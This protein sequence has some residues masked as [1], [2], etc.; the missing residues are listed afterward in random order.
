M[1]ADGKGKGK[2]ATL[3]ALDM[4]SGTGCFKDQSQ[5]SMHVRI[6]GAIAWLAVVKHFFGP[7]EATN[8]IHVFGKV[9]GEFRV[10][11]VVIFARYHRI[12]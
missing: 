3:A 8:L 9:L 11:I 6:G 2:V 5:P 4:S 1:V 10:D 12:F 7:V